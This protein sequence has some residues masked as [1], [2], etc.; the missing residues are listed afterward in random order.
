M[1]HSTPMPT[2]LAIAGG[3]LVLGLLIT[4]FV[5]GGGKAPQTQEIRLAV[6]DTFEK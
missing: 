5:L 6:P 2:I 4:L 1:R 3:V